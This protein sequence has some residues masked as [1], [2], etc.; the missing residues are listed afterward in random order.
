MSRTGNF[1]LVARCKRGFKTGGFTLV[2][3]L[4]VIAIIA[5][6]AAILF[7]AF[8]RAREQARRASCAS[9]MKQ[10]ALGMMQYTQDFDEKMPRY[11]HG[12]GFNGSDGYNDADGIRWGDMIFPYV[13]NIQIYACPSDSVH[14]R[15]FPA[16]NYLDVDTYS[17][18]YSTPDTQIEFNSGFGV[19]SRSLAEIEDPSGTIMLADDSA[20]DLFP[21]SGARIV[22]AASDAVSI[23]F[24]S[25][26]INGMR[27]SGASLTDYNAHAFNAAYAD[28]HVKFT[29]LPDTIGST[30]PYMRAWTV[31]KD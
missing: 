14:I 15:M 20:V 27:H 13:K 5:I 2:E 11:S 29:R 28:G 26:K 18:G 1:C 23:D 8:T 12:G 9:N 16:G 19:A 21:E 31:I 30:A 7:P 22:P 10:L 25:G 3:L 17:Y 4:T 6:I 24:L